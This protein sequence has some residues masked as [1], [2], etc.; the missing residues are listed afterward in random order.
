MELLIFGALA[1]TIVLLALS[2]FIVRQGRMSGDVQAALREEFLKFQSNIHVEMDKARQGV[3]GAKDVISQNA[4]KT[5]EQVHSLG[6][7]VRSL[8]QQQEEA[9]Q[10]GRSL[11]DLLQAPKLR[12]NYGEV[13]LEEVLERVLPLGIWERQYPLEQG[14]IVDCIVRFKDVIVPID[15]KFPRDDYVRYSSAESDEDKSIY[16]KGFEVAIKTQI[17]SIRSKYVKPEL[18]T[19][20]FALMF[21]PS[22]AIYYETIAETNYVG[23]PSGLFE[24][25]QENHVLPVSPNT[26]YAF[27]QVIVLSLKNVEIVK[28]A[29]ELQDGLHRLERDFRLFYDRFVSI[30]TAIDRASEAHRVGGGHVDRYRVRLNEA[31]NI[32]T[33]RLT[34]N[35]EGVLGQDDNQG[36]S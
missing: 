10:L 3:E 7:V 21:I 34:R 31:L 30:G 18:G 35:D 8:V 1:V 11:K 13:I 16:W 20:D 27:L 12:G 9:H 5:L 2:V 33:L 36:V 6:D 22:E 32:G 24:F 17:S 23:N 29:R 25:A 15:A 28:N 26:F 19:T 4:F 14:S